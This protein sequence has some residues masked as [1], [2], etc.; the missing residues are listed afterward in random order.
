MQTHINFS[1]NKWNKK[2]GSPILFWR[3][4]QLISVDSSV[5]IENLPSSEHARPNHAKNLAERMLNAIERNHLKGP[6]T[7]TGLVTLLTWKKRLPLM[8]KPAVVGAAS[9]YERDI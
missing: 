4:R 6:G 1:S 9:C 8:N 5:F 3:K 2:V 7:N